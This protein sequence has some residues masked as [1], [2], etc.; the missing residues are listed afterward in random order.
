MTTST[1]S[2]RNVLAWNSDTSPREI[3]IEY[4]RFFFAPE[5]AE[6]AADGM[7]ATNEIWMVAR[8]RHRGCF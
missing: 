4:C 2:S 3:L 6:T 8:S 1:V 5:V 7:F